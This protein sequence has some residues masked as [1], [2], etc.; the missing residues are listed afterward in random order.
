[1]AY[2]MKGPSLYKDKLTVN[3]NG[4]DNKP[5]GRSKSSMAQKEVHSMF[6]QNKPGA[7]DMKTGKYEHSFEKGGAPK[8]EDKAFNKQLGDIKNRKARKEEG[9]KRDT[10]HKEFVKKNPGMFKKDKEGILRDKEGRSVR[11]ANV[12][13]QR[14]SLQRMDKEGAKA[15]KRG[16]KAAE[17]SQKPG[18]PKKGETEAEFLARMKKQGMTVKPEVNV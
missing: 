8:K 2:K 17:E 10:S 4:Y 9:K 6:Y 12:A 7:P 14:R 18:A 16:R 13:E 5:D 15:M 1:M 11:E 3:R